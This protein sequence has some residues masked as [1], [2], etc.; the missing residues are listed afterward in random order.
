MM[1][2]EAASAPFLGTQIYSYGIYVALGALLMLLVLLST[3]RRVKLKGGTAQLCM[4]LALPLGLLGARLF[5]CLLEKG[6]YQIASL[7]AVLWI[8]GGGYSMFGTLLGAALAACL[9]ARITKQS[10][11]RLLDALAP[12]LLAFIALAR[13]GEG[14][15]E[16]GISRPLL[17]DYLK[18]TFLAVEGDW[19]FYL[20]TYLIESFVAAVLSAIILLDIRS[21]RRA[22]NTLWLAM[23]LF[24][25]TQ[26]LME[27]LRFDQHL[28]FSFVAAQQVLS[29]VMMFVPLV[30]FALR[31]KDRHKLLTWGA[32]G[33]LPLLAVG[34]IGLEFV[35]DRSGLDRL[36]TY[37]LY[38]VMLA[39]P[40][41]LGIQLRTRSEMI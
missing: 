27:S 12:A 8:S 10:A 22:G 40:V 7:K 9:A 6:F 39:V 11:L 29:A 13:L 16:V 36:I 34:I 14:Y 30:V 26:V 4:A 41:V 21:T 33:L 37:A 28:R 5:Y 3:C 19:D 23:L 35:V 20:R 17:N 24:G 38:T 15:T 31:V 25:A 2:G 18:T 32:I 1:Y